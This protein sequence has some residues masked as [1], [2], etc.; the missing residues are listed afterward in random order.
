MF[1]ACKQFSRHRAIRGFTLIEML[2]T[3]TL[4]SI[5]MSV[6]LVGLQSGI[7]GW[8]TLARHQ[9]QN[10]ELEKAM[11]RL[12]TDFR[13]L[14]FASE[15]LPALLEAESTVTADALSLTVLGPRLPQRAGRGAVWYRVDY[16]VR[17]AG[18]GAAPALFRR[19]VPCVTAVPNEAAAT[20]ELLLSDARGFSVSYATPDGNRD[21]WT[22]PKHLPTGVTVTVTAGGLR[23]LRMSTP[24]P[25]AIQ[26]AP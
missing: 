16:T 11:E 24:I 7:R 17:A 8:R 14:Y 3:L 23:P 4:Y 9:A 25:C 1:T 13:H 19:A 20:E 18:E 12:R 21:V 10:A 6:L 22:D 2:V 5:V 15:E 26:G